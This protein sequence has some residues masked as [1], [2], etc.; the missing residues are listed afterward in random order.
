MLERERDEALAVLERERDEASLQLLQYQGQDPPGQDNRDFII[1]ET[2]EDFPLD[3]NL[4]GDQHI[5]SSEGQVCS[6]KCKF[7]SL[8]VTGSRR[9]LQEECLGPAYRSLIME[10][11]QHRGHFQVSRRAIP[12]QLEGVLGK[13]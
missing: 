7:Y 5:H 11:E 13:K 4:L 3:N 9:V 1:E 6:V 12:G 2:F 10:L 8:S